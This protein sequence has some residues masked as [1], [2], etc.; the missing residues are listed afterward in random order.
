[1][2]SITKF[3][4]HQ[5]VTTAT[6]TLPGATSYVS[7]Q[8]PA[9]STSLTNRSMDG[10]VGTSQSSSAIT[11]LANTSAQPTPIARFISAPIAA[12]T[13]AQQNFIVHAAGSDSNTNSNFGG[14]WSLVVWR[15]ST[16]AIVG[17]MADNNQQSSMNFNFTTQTAAN[18]TSLLATTNSV[19]A[20]DADLIIIEMWRDS[21]AQGMATA[22]TNTLFYDGTTEDSTTSNAA[23]LL[24]A[25]PVEM[26][27]GK[28]QAFAK[29]MVL[30]NRRILL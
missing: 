16:G 8:A 10:T 1:L 21:I 24:F 23:Y 2:P 6:G 13:I 22:Y 14:I 5:A 25:N 20:A 12:Q 15:P 17:R 18:N 29:M 19:V 11:T 9:A 3:Y 27:F 26:W 28:A 4:L 30:N 7:A